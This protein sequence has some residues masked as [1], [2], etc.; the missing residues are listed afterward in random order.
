MPARP[1]PSHCRLTPA[2]PATS[3]RAIHP[4]TGPKTGGTELS[5]SCSGVWEVDTAVVCFEMA[6]AETHTV[7]ATFVAPNQLRCEVPPLRMVEALSPRSEGGSEAPEEEEEE[8]GGTGGGSAASG[9]AAR[10]AFFP[11]IVRVS[12]NGQDFSRE[13]LSFTYYGA[14]TPPMPPARGAYVRS[15]AAVPPH[16][17]AGGIARAPTR[18]QTHPA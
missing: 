17:A 7:R 3:L 1:C 5:L 12:M 18:T 6:G 14:C 13:R 16:A 8:E 4:T 2:L 11:V 15:S 9:A 10:N